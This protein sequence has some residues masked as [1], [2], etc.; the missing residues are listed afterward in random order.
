[1]PRLSCWFV[2]SSLLHLAVGVSLGG[3]IL[4]AKGIP[5][6]FGWSWSFLA[7]HIQLLVGGWLTQLAMGVAFWILP[8]PRTGERLR[9]RW[10]WASFGALNIGVDGAALL[11]SVRAFIPA[12]PV[13]NLIILMALL[14]TLALLAF[15]YHAWPR[16]RPFGT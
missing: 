1:M 16:V 9:V 4:S 15:A 10:A 7:A 12:A 5:P 8:R 6:I 14:Q 3:L 13:T 11:L 2:R